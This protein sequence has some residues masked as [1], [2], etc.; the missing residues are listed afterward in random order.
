LLPKAFTRVETNDV[1]SVDPEPIDPVPVNDK[2]EVDEL[3]PE[4]G[5][6]SKLIVFGT[7]G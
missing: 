7:P 2:P 1:K 3:E 4:M 6:H 5:A